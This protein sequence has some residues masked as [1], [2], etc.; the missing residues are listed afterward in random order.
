MRACVRACVR[1]RMRARVGVRVRVYVHKRC[2]LMVCCVLTVGVHC[3]RGG[4]EGLQ[5]EAAGRRAGVLVRAAGLGLG[6]GLG[7]GLV[8]CYGFEGPGEATVVDA[9]VS[10]PL[11]E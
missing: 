2:L 5:K 11:E 8:T 4:F 3:C 10:L 7:W 9:L 1:A 6:L